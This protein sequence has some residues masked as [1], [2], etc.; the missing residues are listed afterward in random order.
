[1]GLLGADIIVHNL[2]QII[3]IDRVGFEK[4]LEFIVR[5]IGTK[6][7]ERQGMPNQRN[8]FYSSYLVLISIGEEII[9][10]LIY[11]VCFCFPLFYH[12]QGSTGRSYLDRLKQ[13]QIDNSV[14]NDKVLVVSPVAT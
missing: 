9:N 6:E 2:Q 11:N 13:C 7:M 1:M 8:L 4:F 12:Q 14:G 10:L 3:C 5:I